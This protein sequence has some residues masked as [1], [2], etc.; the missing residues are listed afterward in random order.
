[1]PRVLLSSAR[2]AD[3]PT[4][5]ILASNLD[6][7]LAHEGETPRDGFL[8][9]FQPYAPPVVFSVRQ[10]VALNSVNIVP[11]IYPRRDGVYTPSLAHAHKLQ[12]LPT[13]C[14]APRSAT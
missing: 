8:C 11:E 2:C 5:Y 7:Y 3:H 10:S 14:A 6:R 13:C 1:M 12:E 9:V 4:S